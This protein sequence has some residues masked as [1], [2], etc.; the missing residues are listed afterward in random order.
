MSGGQSMVLAVARS[1]TLKTGMTGTEHAVTSSAVEGA[2]DLDSAEAVAGR[3][4]V[5]LSNARLDE[6]SHQVCPPPN[7]VH[8]PERG[9]VIDPAGTLLDQHQAD[10]V[11]AGIDRRLGDIRC[12]NPADLDDHEC[13][14][15]RAAATIALHRVAGEGARMSA[16]PTRTA[17]A[18]SL[19][20]RVTSSGLRTPDS[21]THSTSS[22]SV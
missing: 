10:P 6:D 16:S 17:S 7:G 18:P 9:R 2:V 5:A 20:R 11:R 3:R 1:S 22:G 15:V 4:L 8:N 13:V 21:A 12:A 19:I 14:A